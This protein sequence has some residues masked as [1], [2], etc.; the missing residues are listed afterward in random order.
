MAVSARAVRPP[1]ADNNVDVRVA[2]KNVEVEELLTTFFLSRI[3]NLIVIQGD[4]L[5]E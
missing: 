3:F 1:K 2:V 5:C 4:Y